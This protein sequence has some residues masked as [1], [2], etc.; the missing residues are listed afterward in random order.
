MFTEIT[1]A[2]GLSGPLALK[3]AVART[4]IP[5]CQRPGFVHWVGKNDPA[6]PNPGTLRVRRDEKLDELTLQQT[7]HHSWPE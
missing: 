5:R 2:R 7:G 6:P 3:A 1:I 4:E